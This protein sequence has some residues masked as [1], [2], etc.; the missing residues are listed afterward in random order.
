MSVFEYYINEQKRAPAGQVY[1]G[2][3]LAVCLFLSFFLGSFLF[4]VIIL[5]ISTIIFLE[6][7]EL[8]G[9]EFGRIKVVFGDTFFSYGNKKYLYSNCKSFTFHE[10]I[11]TNWEESFLRL[12]FLTKGLTDLFVFVPSEVHT[13][14][15]YDI[16]RQSVKEDK[17]KKL[18]FTDQ[19]FLRFF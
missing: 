1:L 12:T 16:I 5:I 14:K 10:D 9:D 8:E 13:R 15:I 7:E 6:K 19:I 2:S 11:S 4:F 3:F 18:S 17:T